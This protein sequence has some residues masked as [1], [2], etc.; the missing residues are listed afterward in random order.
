[1]TALTAETRRLIALSHGADDPPPSAEAAVRDRLI[2][3][4]G[5]TA[6]AGAA[7]AAAVAA[8]DA[9][10]AAGAAGAGVLSGGGT[11]AL[12]KTVAG[13]VLVAGLGT[14]AMQNEA[15]AERAREWPAQVA[16]QTKVI[17]RRTWQLMMGRDET[18]DG[19]ASPEKP[20]EPSLGFD[21]R[22]HALLMAIA[23]RP[24]RPVAKEAELVLILDAEEALTAG[25]PSLAAR[26][27]DQHE[28]RFAEGALSDNREAMRVLVDC[29]L[30]AAEKARA[31]ALQFVRKYPASDQV[32][33][34]RACAF[35]APV[36]EAEAPPPLSPPRSDKPNL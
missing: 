10:G 15:I 12:V 21:A 9:A 26:Y 20:P 1:M 2:A 3:E 28:T 36:V 7:S 27:L 33:R 19:V 31:G 32:A 25:D 35:A 34:L 29:A 24:D 22:R 5:V 23:R 11:T 4:L 18:Q 14:G 30:G 16:V 8:T 6:L 13:L 17:A